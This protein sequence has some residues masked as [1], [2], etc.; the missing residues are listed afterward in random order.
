M[1]YPC[2]VIRDL[3]PLYHDDVCSSESRSAVEAH[4]CECTDCKKILDDLNIMPEPQENVAS[5]APLL[6]IQ[7]RWIHEKRKSLWIGLGIALFLLLIIIGHSVLTQWYCIPM[8][9][10]DLVLMGLYQTSDGIIHVP[11]DDLYDLNYYSTAVEVG[12]DGYAYISAYRPILAKKT[13][14]PH[15]IGTSEIGFDPGSAFAWL[16]ENSMV[17]VAK[18]YLGIKNDPGNSILVWEKGMEV[19]AATAEEEAEYRAH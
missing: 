7:K 2:G 8:G 17:P 4:C 6:P 12:D 16:N 11:F 15:R 18:V 1:N 19:R 5:A 3:L 14:A 13:N 10:D 9:K